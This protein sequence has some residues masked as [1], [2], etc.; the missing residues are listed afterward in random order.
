MSD[1]HPV[2]E[3]LADRWSQEREGALAH[4]ITRTV[5][6]RRQARRLTGV[7]LVLACAAA[8]AI[9]A[10]KSLRAPA[11]AL[12]F[13]DGSTAVAL[14]PETRLV[15]LVDTAAAVTIALERG[16][17]RFD[18]VPDPHRRFRVEAA[19]ITVEVIGTVF[20]V[21]RLDAHVRVAVERGTVRVGD[22]LLT[23]G[24][25][26]LFPLAAAIDS[27]WRALARGGA[28][29]RAW[30]RL[31]AGAPVG[32]EPNELLLASDAARLSGHPADAATYLRRL[33]AAYPGDPRA[34]LAAFTLGRVLLDELGRP[35]DA[36]LA[37]VRAREL[38]EGG[39]LAE[40]ALG[41]E[42]EAWA[43]A[44]DAGLARAAAERYLARYPDGARAAFVRR[45]GGIR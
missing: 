23:V 8:A 43:R 13:A 32:D 38:D 25:S 14:H 33:L 31:D 37:F 19:G 21:E 29:E 10:V 39:P 18:V 40:D 34:P 4:R 41:R 16:A 20:E 3:V 11:Q 45:H 24:Q 1:L 27:D 5:H 35:R 30:A 36:A 44:G 9:F 7:A 15:A 22:R 42:V 17:A 26:G 28:F 6:R 12:R 2:R